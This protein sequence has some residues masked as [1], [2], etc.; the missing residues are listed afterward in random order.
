MYSREALLRAEYIT[1]YLST[2]LQT[3]A[4]PLN[5]TLLKESKSDATFSF[6]DSLASPNWSLLRQNPAPASSTS[7]RILG[8]RL[9]E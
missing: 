8:G 1:L 4:L 5:Q 6:S 9:H 7:N 3:S 2:P